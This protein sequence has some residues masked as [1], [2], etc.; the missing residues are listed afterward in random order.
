VCA[1]K[2]R[3]S[4]LEP[5]ATNND[6]RVSYHDPITLEFI[7]VVIWLPYTSEFLIMLLWHQFINVLWECRDLAGCRS[8]RCTTNVVCATHFFPQSHSIA[9]D[10]RSSY[11]RRTVN[12]ST[13]TV[14]NNDF[15]VIF[16]SNSFKQSIILY[17]TT[18]SLV[19]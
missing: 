14:E 1:W 12:E 9:R 18:V 8:V 19:L 4:E 2:M 13:A 15:T 3:G 5:K 11:F 17:R 16:Y 7:N 10:P 6:I